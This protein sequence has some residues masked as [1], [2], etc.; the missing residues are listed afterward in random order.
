MMAEIKFRFSLFRHCMYRFGFLAHRIR[1]QTKLSPAFRNGTV[2]G[3]I[4]SSDVGTRGAAGCL[5]LAKPLVPQ[6]LVYLKSTLASSFSIAASDSG[7]V[8]KSG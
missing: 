7:S 4:Y 6:P 5:R 2:E 8:S 1:A 3:L